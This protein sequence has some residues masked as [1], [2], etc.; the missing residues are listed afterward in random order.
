MS[1]RSTQFTRKFRRALYQQLGITVKFLTAHELE[2]D[3]QI[4]KA[5][6]QLEWYLKSYINY[7]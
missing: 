6:Q 1:D 3:G 4:R 2:T 5:N 7:Q